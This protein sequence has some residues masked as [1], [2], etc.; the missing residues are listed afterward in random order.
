M[1][2]ER[3]SYNLCIV[4]FGNVGQALV[5]L[6]QQKSSELLEKYGIEWNITGIASRSLGWIA[7]SEALDP[8]QV[9]DADARSRMKP[10]AQNVR[11]WL[12]IARADV[13]FEASSLNRHNGQPAIDYLRAALE[14]GAHAI[15]ANKGPVVFALS[16]LAELA[17]SKGR[18]FL[19]EST[20][21]DGVPIF[22]MFR[23]TLPAIK[24]NGFRGILNATTNVVLAGMESGLPLKEAVRKAQE[25]GIAESDPADDLEGWDAAVKVAAL[26]IVVL[27]CSL[28]LS[29]VER[30]GITGLDAAAVQA[31]RQAGTPYK[32]VC[33]AHREGERV[34]A[35]VRPERLP[36]GDPLSQI[37]GGSS[38][39]HFELDI[40]PGLTMVEH[41]AG[42]DT[43]AYG[44]LADFVRA[45]GR[46][47]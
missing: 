18:R 20:V 31:A 45:V 13:L 22:S 19:F 24:V 10:S 28:P 42:L 25:M 9:L 47:G 39:V 17:R 23:E 35:I 30:E 40:L 33:R 27:G 4:G 36:L 6:L 11:E 21:M 16:E 29:E 43:T 2:S 3:R 32:L 26:A 14:S 8:D 46:I 7:S 34:R 15:S 44:M 12:K 37:D 1:K 38:C 41:D 5:K